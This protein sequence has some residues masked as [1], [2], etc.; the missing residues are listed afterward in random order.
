MQ[1]LKYDVKNR[2]ITAARDEFK[3][4]GYSSASMRRISQNAGAALGNLY[5]YFKNKEDL[6]DSL[7]GPVCDNIYEFIAKI[8]NVPTAPSDP[9][10][11]AGP[12]QLREINAFK[13]D[14][15]EICKDHNTELFILMNKS[16]GSK[17]ENV[18][19]DMISIISDI[20][21]HQ[22]L[23][24]AEKK[25]IVIRD[26]YLATVLSTSLVE[27]FSLIIRKYENGEDAKMLTDQLINIIFTDIENRIG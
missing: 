13:E 11:P 20:L 4:K 26:G 17:F 23:I 12:V 10:A 2:I 6:F 27:G 16:R 3:E 21:T 18:K 8:R 14:L 25:G 24:P 19:S 9:N 1:Y 15:L 7:V 22:L 5:R